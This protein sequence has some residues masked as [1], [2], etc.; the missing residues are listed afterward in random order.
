[1]ISSFLKGLLTACRARI[2]TQGIQSIIDQG[3]A[4]GLL[5]PRLAKMIQSI[6]DFRDTIVREVMVP[7]TQ[8]V[9][10]N[11]DATIEEIIENIT[12]YG[13]T[14]MPVC[15]DNIDNIIGILNVKDL[16]KFWSRPVRE[17]D[18][19]ASIR[20]PFYIPETK[21]VHLLLQE[22]KQ[23]K[24]HMAIVIDEYGGTSGL[25]TLEDLLE[26]IVGK[27]SDEYDTNDGEVLELGD[28]TYLVDSRVDLEKI[29][30]L[31]GVEFP[32]G[33]YETLSGLILHEIKRIPLIGE[34]LEID[35]IDIMI[36]GADERSIKRVRISKKRP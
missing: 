23:K 8:I 15:I 20:K 30:D 18:I 13:H 5:D 24:Y 10:I 3:K 1:M 9:A 16:L 29:E 26:E 21:N 32:R 36:E 31:L 2:K 25:V 14:R 17:A 19:R 11:V 34:R 22:L 4:E 7:R 27:I 6:M 28:G 33:K 12:K 35:D